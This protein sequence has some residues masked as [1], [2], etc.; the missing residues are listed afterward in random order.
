MINAASTTRS[1]APIQVCVAKAS[2]IRWQLRMK[3]VA[4]AVVD[5][6]YRCTLIGLTPQ[7]GD[8]LHRDLRIT[9]LLAESRLRFPVFS[10]FLRKIEKLLRVTAALW[11]NR[12]DICCV[13][14]FPVL[15]LVALKRLFRRFRLIYIGDELEYSR[16]VSG[17][18]GVLR[19]ALVKQCLRLLLPFCDVIMQ[20]DVSRAEHMA[21]VYHR[22][23]KIQVLRN[24]PRSRIPAVE[25]MDLH[26]RLRWPRETVIFMYHGILSPGRGIERSLGVLG[27]IAAD[28]PVG[29][30]I[31]G[32][33]KE[34]YT[35]YLQ[36]LIEHY[37]RE[38]DQFKAYLAGPMEYEAL[39]PWIQGADVG[40]CLIENTCLSYYLAAPSKLYQYMQAG[41]PVIG[42]DFPEFRLVFRE[43]DCGLL[44]DPE[45]ESALTNAFRGMATDEKLRREKGSAGRRAAMERYNWER[46]QEVL[47]RALKGVAPLNPTQSA[48]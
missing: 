23:D 14:D 24:V 19:N 12:F 45:D 4:E 40:I 27:N 41:I 16:N 36:G 34:R 20:A 5:A 28:H 22:T 7:D 31:V 8:T 1:N 42:S 18:F 25:P 43:A 3:L 47:L 26:Q 32:W 11:L 17:L 35:T 48:E 46:E 38:A 13:H 37:E 10:S 33:G 2:D 30:L 29:M 15:V 21:R 44:A 39:L 9:Y 6:G